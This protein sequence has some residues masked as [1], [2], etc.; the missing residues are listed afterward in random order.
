VEIG[1]IASNQPGSYNFTPF[2]SC[3][4]RV[5]M[6]GIFALNRGPEPARKLLIRPPFH[7]AKTPYESAGVPVRKKE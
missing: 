7:V 1:Q 4:I 3:N 6:G 2:G 5:Q